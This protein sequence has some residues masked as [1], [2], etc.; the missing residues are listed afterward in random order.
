MCIY[1]PKDIILNQGPFLPVT[2][3]M[4]QLECCCFD[5][6]PPVERKVFLN[7]NIDVLVKKPEGILPR[8]EQCW[9]FD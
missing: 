2:P 6:I 9:L 5:L 1:S 8:Q 4:V 3:V 7:S